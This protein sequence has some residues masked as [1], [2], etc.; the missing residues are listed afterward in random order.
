MIFVNFAF[1]VESEL[2]ATV[3]QTL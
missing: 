1:L 3:Y 2:C